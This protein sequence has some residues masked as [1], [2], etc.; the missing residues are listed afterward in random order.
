MLA[1][2]EVRT[3]FLDKILTEFP[4]FALNDDYMKALTKIITTKVK[5]AQEMIA[6]YKLHLTKRFSLPNTIFIDRFS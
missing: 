6:Q 5:Q 3:F 4:V 2:Q 1:L